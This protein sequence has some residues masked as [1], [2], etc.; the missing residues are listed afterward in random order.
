MIFFKVIVVVSIIR[1]KY[2]IVI[3]SII[4]FSSIVPSSDYIY[5]IQIYNSII[6]N[7]FI[8]LL[9]FLEIVTLS[10][11]MLNVLNILLTILFNDS[12]LFA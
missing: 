7:I 5:T 9:N 1:K 11:I 4:H 3:V 12:F 2:V 6:N 10:N 8:T